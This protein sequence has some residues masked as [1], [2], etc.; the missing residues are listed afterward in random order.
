MAEIIANQPMTLLGQRYQPGDRL[1]AERLEPRRLKLLIEQ[2]R[3]V[4][5]RIEKRGPG[6]PRK[7]S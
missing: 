5:S 3:A 4:E 6:R 2:R 7:E 1:P